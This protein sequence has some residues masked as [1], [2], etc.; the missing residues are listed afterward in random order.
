M[1]QE[2]E[3]RYLPWRAYGDPA[4]GAL[5]QEKRH[6]YVA[7]FYY[8]DYTLAPSCALQFRQ[9]AELDREATMDAYVA[10]FGSGGKRRFGRSSTMRVYAIPSNRARLRTS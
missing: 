8:I 1:W 7:P 6:I 9:R 5:W 10:L 2:M 4:Q 3:R